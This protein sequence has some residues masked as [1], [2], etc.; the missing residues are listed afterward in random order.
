MVRP[1]LLEPDVDD[2]STTATPLASL[3]KTLRSKNAGVEMVTFDIF[4]KD[5]A[6]FQRATSSQP[7]SPDGIA[8][9]YRIDPEDIVTYVV[10]PQLDALKF[11]IR[12]PRRSGGP[13]DADVF[14]SQ[15]YAP[16]LDVVIP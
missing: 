14:G 13:G 2:S 6:G 1:N 7:L 12:R 10:M 15:Q 5:A 4:F 9:L 16:L 8:A 3:V 11:T